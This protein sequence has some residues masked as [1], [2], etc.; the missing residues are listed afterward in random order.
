MELTDTHTHLY[1]P[2]FKE[3]IEKIIKESLSLGVNRI[4]LPNI[5]QESIDPMLNLAET[6][7]Q[8]VFPMMGLHPCSVGPDYEKVLEDMRTLFAQHKFYGVGE[9]G[10]DLYWDKTYLKEQVKSLEIQITWAKEL[11]L[12]LILHVRDSFNEVFEVIDRYNDERLTGIFHCFTGNADQ[13]RHVMSY[14]GFKMGIGG[15]VTYKTST[16]PQVLGQVPL[17]YLVLETDSPYLPPVPF[18]GKR[19]ETPYII[20]VAKK[21]AEIYGVSTEEIARVTTANARHLFNL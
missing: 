6:W 13:A 11:G 5:D 15:V 18:R 17:D 10:I 2:E 20:Y 12:P 3:D 7:P 9:T 4:F 21:L 19:N 16:L 8:Q 1:L 14:K